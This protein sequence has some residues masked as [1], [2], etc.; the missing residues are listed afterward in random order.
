MRVGDQVWPGRT[1]GDI[2]ELGRTEAL[3]YVL[4]ADGGGL[5]PGKPA[6][7]VLS[8][9]P[10]LVIEGK[11][12]RVDALAKPRFRW[13]PIQYFET[14]VS[15]TPPDGATLK[16]GQSVSVEILIEDVP[17]AIAVPRQAIFDKDGAKV[18]YKDQRGTLAP[19]EVKVA[20]YGLGAA[21]V[22][23]GLAEGDRIALRDPTLTASQ[24]YSPPQGK[25]GSPKS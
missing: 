15:L 1:I 12:A 13:V 6:K 25:G 19:V 2:P 18:V 10:D 9:R 5:E 24:I 14:I 3:V 11:I 21:L 22:E 17:D 23:E 4:E 7:I 16:P 20:R 8:A